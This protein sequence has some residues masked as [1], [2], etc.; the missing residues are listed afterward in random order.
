MITALYAIGYT[1]DEIY[2]LFK[3]YARE[4]NAVTQCFIFSERAHVI[5]V[6]QVVVVDVAVTPI[7]Y[8]TKAVV[9][10]VNTPK[11]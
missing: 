6:I 7:E 5:V 10:T 3:K 8:P 2:E 4:A 9:E 1:P 11:R